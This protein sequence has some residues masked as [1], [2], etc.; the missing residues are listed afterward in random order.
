LFVLDGLT[1]LIAA[2]VTPKADSLALLPYLPGYS[3][4]NGMAMRLL[5]LSAYM[6]EWLFNA[7][8]QDNYV[9]EKVRLVRKW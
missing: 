6:Q 5:Q 7:S 8:A 1:F 3:V 9:P 2:L 4:Y